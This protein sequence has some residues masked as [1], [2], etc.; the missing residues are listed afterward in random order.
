MDMIGK[1]TTISQQQPKQAASTTSK[2]NA[3]QSQSR[4][5]TST[6]KNK[7]R[8]FFRKVLRKEGVLMRAI[9]QLSVFCAVQIFY[10][11]LPQLVRASAGVAA[12]AG[13]KSEEELQPVFTPAGAS[14]ALFLLLLMQTSVGGL[15][16]LASSSTQ[17]RVDSLATYNIVDEGMNY[18]LGPLL[19][20]QVVS[21]FTSAV[22]GTSGS[23]GASNEE[24]VQV[25]TEATLR[26]LSCFFVAAAALNVGVEAVNQDV[27]K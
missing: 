27:E 15:Q 16:V 5:A 20:Q 3:E 14:I 10:T 12:G 24:Q 4:S 26:T 25:A 13:N 18:V 17:Q 7:K 2:A 23:G 22:V 19:S 1:K 9:P 6:S 8:N 21:F 11:L